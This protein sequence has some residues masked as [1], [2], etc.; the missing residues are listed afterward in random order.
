MVV[1]I[2]YLCLYL[3]CS[4]K[5]TTNYYA[6]IYPIL[7][8]GYCPFAFL[9]I[10][11][12]PN[13]CKEST[14]VYENKLALIPYLVIQIFTIILIYLSHRYLNTNTEIAQ[15]TSSMIL[16]LLKILLS[17]TILVCYLF[18]IKFSFFR[19]NIRY[20]DI[21]LIL[22]IFLM[23]TVFRNGDLIIHGKADFTHLLQSATIIK[24]ATQSIQEML[25]P[26]IFEELLYRGLLI[27]GL[28]SFGLSDEKTNILQAVLFGLSHFISFGNA[29]LLWLL[30]TAYQI[31]AGY[32]IG[33]VYF[34]TKS[35]TPCILLH[36]LGNISI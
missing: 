20:Q 27:S 29:S 11:F 23:K 25:Y 26:G 34:K 8:I 33:K 19:W 36:A 32:V 17:S 3:Y 16:L 6:L 5:G 21:L 13:G 28:K 15:K 18:K 9:L 14:H 2:C 35:L 31:A 1:G 22:I 12:A 7:I 24:L 10:H 30:H 4:L